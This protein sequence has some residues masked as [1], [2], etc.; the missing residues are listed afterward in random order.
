MKTLRTIYPYG[1]CDKY[2]KEK[3]IPHD[4]PKGKLF[5]PLPRYGERFPGLDTRTRNGSRNRDEHTNF[6]NIFETHFFDLF[7]SFE[8]SIRADSIRKHLDQLNKKEVKKVINYKETVANIDT[9]DLITYG[10]GLA[11][12][13]CEGSEFCDPR[14]GHIITGDLRIVA[15]QKLRT[16]I[17]RGPNFREAKTIHW[18]HCKTEIS[19]GL[20]AYIAKVCAKFSGIESTI[21]ERD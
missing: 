5:P 12:C 16:L 19:S 6:F 9:N 3:K 21:F 11:S 10:T 1:L 13:D 2:K 4:A 14:H 15:N 20:D 8:P 18:G 17:A 7:L